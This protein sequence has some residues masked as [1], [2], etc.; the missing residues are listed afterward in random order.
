MLSGGVRILEGLS[1]WLQRSGQVVLAFMAVTIF[2]DAMMRYLFTAPTTWSLEINS[3]LLVYLAIIPA[4][5]TLRRG[6]QISISLLPDKLPLRGRA[7]LFVVISIVGVIFSSILVW[8]G[9]MLA[10]DAWLHEERVSS[11]FG[12]PMVFPYSILPIGFGVLAAQ[13][14]ID[15]LRALGVAGGWLPPERLQPGKAEARDSERVEL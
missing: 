9:Y 13:F 1:R 11:V 3:F 10:H 5:D 14:V 8:R 4:A 6:E 7:A 15:G 12:T 2:Y